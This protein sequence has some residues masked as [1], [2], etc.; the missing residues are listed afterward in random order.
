MEL[1]FSDT[2]EVPTEFNY[3]PLMELWNTFIL[4]QIDKVRT[5]PVVS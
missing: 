3:A 5:S 1:V 4:E 2:E